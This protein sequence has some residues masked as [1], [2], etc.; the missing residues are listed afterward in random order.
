[1]GRRAG[2]KRALAQSSR[3]RCGVGHSPLFMAGL[4]SIGP[5]LCDPFQGRHGSSFIGFRGYRCAQA[6]QQFEF[7]EE[8]P[9]IRPLSDYSLTSLLQFRRERKCDECQIG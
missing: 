1:M 4:N 6:Q 5:T 9:I 8:H 3:R 2:G 7:L